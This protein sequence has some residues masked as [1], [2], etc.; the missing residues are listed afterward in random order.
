MQESDPSL[1]QKRFVLRFSTEFFLKVF[2]EKVLHRESET[3]KMRKN[4]K[5]TVI[6]PW[7]KATLSEEVGDSLKRVRL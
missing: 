2:L 3:H 7:L 4:P 1:A 5:H 6:A